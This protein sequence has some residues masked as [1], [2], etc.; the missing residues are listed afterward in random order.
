MG[1]SK[2]FLESS[3]WCKGCWRWSASQGQCLQASDLSSRRMSDVTFLLGFWGRIKLGTLGDW[4]SPAVDVQPWLPFLLLGKSLQWS[5]HHV[6]LFLVV[7][8]FFSTHSRIVTMNPSLIIR[9]QLEPI[10]NGQCSEISEFELKFGSWMSFLLLRMRGMFVVAQ[11]RAD[12]HWA[13]LS[14]S[15]CAHEPACLHTPLTSQHAVRGT[16]CES[17]LSFHVGPW[18]W[19]YAVRSGSSAFTH[20]SSPGKHFPWNLF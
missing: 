11:G 7:S 15:E 2:A 10:K 1:S 19:I 14:V 17:V 20:L 8:I 13:E 4:R 18:D 6:L 12:W 9:P 16:F 3:Q 5:S